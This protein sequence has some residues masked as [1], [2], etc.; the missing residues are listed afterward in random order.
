MAPLKQ[1][2]L[3]SQLSIKVIQD[4]LE[5]LISR[6]KNVYYEHNE[7]TNKITEIVEE[8]VRDEVHDYIGK[9]LP[10]YLQSD[11]LMKLVEQTEFKTPHLLVELLFSKNFQSF[12]LELTNSKKDFKKTQTGP[13]RINEDDL[14]KVLN[15]IEKVFEETGAEEFKHLQR[16]VIIDKSEDPDFQGDPINNMTN[17]NLDDGEHWS[18]L[19]TSLNTVSSHL[20]L[21]P[22]LTHLVLPFASDQILT[23]ISCSRT[24]KLFQNVYRSTVTEQGIMSLVSGPVHSSLTHLVLSLNTHARVPGSVVRSLLLAAG[25]LRVLELGGAGHTKSLYFQGGDAKRRNQVYHSVL[26]LSENNPEY[27][28]Q[29]ARMLIFIEAERSVELGSLV[30]QAPHLEDLTLFGWE[31]I[32]LPRLDWNL[33]IRNIVTLELVGQGCTDDTGAEDNSVFDVTMFQEARSLRS[34]QVA[35]WGDTRVQVDRLMEVLPHLDKLY[36]EDVKLCLSEEFR[37][38]RRVELRH[39]LVQL[40]IFHCSTRELD[41]LFIL[42]LIFNKLKHLTV[43][44]LYLDD[45]AR[46]LPFHFHLPDRGEVT[47]HPVADLK[48]LSKMTDLETLHLNVCYPSRLAEHDFSLPGLLIRDFASLRY[49]GLDNYLNRN[50]S[51]L[52]YTFQR[53]NI[54]KKLQWFLHQYNRDI[55]VNVS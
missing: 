52:S 4:A 16:F 7:D 12:G 24:L 23:N 47:R 27:E 45:P 1:P 43:S 10:S 14:K 8:H 9:M 38:K 11:L 5:K 39:E 29:L 20:V 50:A 32:R 37:S 41:L 48:L 51:V 18:S 2:S 46:G 36:L 25:Q 19:M 3:L 26:R 15:S 53:N 35:G 30:R 13:I 6:E 54:N 55:T 28:C 34:L 40:S 33:L 44:S 22:A 17:T 49:L 31:H 42:P 21:C